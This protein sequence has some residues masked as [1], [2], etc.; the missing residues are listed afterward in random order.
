MSGVLDYLFLDMNNPI[1]LCLS[2]LLLFV[3]GCSDRQ[4]QTIYLF[5]RN[6]PEIETDLKNSKFEK[7]EFSS[8]GGSTAYALK[9]GKQI[10]DAGVTLVVNNEC[11]SNCAE[12]ILPLSSAV[13]FDKKPIIAFHGNIQSYRYFTEKLAIKN[14]QFCNWAHELHLKKVLSQ[15][16]L[17]TDFWKEQMKRLKPNVSFKYDA[18]KCPKRDYNFENNYW[19]PTSTQLRELWGLEF[20]GELCADYLKDCKKR[21]DY[22]WLKGTRVVLGDE[23]YTSKGIRMFRTPYP[24]R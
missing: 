9:L 15:K 5:E 3:L 18:G 7:F 16:G 22:H 12:V 17:N 24:I 14:K 11:T 2:A 20:D 13:V 10:K 21:I 23:V 1:R 4:S 19:L 8:K 6:A